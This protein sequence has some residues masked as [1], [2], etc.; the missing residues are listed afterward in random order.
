MQI[1]EDMAADEVCQ[2]IFGR[3][4]AEEGVASHMAARGRLKA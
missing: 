3:Q 1:R 2:H 4:E